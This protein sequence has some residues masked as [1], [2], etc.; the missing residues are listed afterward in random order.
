MENKRAYLQHKDTLK[1]YGIYSA[2]AAGIASL[3]MLLLFCAPCFSI[4]GIYNF[5]LLSDA[6]NS[7]KA[8]MEGMSSL[9]I[10]FA[11]YGVAGTIMVGT[12]FIWLLIESIKMILKLKNLDEYSIMVYDNIVH[13]KN[14]KSKRGQWGN[15][16]WGVFYAGLV[17]I[18]L[19]V[20]L[21]GRIFGSIDILDVKDSLV[22]KLMYVDGVSFWG[23]IAIIMLVA[24]IVLNII[25][26]SYRNKVKK[27]IIKAEYQDVLAET[28]PEV[29]VATIVA[30]NESV[31]QNQNDKKV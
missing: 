20:V 25:A 17:F 18:I 28:K 27:A 14:E 3:A 9:S 15:G 2:I 7:I 30:S 21:L 29:N 4:L 24:V 11:F 6:I 22:C 23:I 16:P 31:E 13:R 26:K 19:D 8:I 10:V 5:S 1:K 12:S